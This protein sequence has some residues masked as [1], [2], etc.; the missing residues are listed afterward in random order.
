MDRHMRMFIVGLTVPLVAFAAIALIV[1]PDSLLQWLT[2]GATPFVASAVVAMVYAYR[3]RGP[4][5][6][7]TRRR[8][9][10]RRP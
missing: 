4:I 2:V 8:P 3:S 10:A 1:R 5:E 6:A 7:P 9:G